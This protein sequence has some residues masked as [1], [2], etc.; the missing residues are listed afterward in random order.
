M[1]SSFFILADS[2]DILIEKH[3]RGLMNRSICEYF[4][5]QVSQSKQNGSSIPPIISTPK[6]YL[7]NIQKQHIYLLGVCQSEVS[8]LLVVDFLQ[9]I[10]ETFEEYFGRTITSVT[11]KENFVHVYQLLD[12]MTDNGFP[13]TTELNF[14]K[15]MIKPPGVLSNVIS[16]VT[17]TSNITDILPNGSLGAIQWRKTGIKYTQNKIFFDIIE[18]IDCILDSNGYIVSSEI[19][20]EILCHCN[21][22]GMPDLTMTFNN[23]R[24]LD[25]VSFHPC[26][27]YSRWEND[28]VLSFIPPDGNFK[29][30]TYRVKG[31]NQFPIYVKPQISYSEGSSSMGRVNVTIGAKGYNVQNKLS[32]EDVVATI[33]FSK[34]T[35]STNLTANIG[36]FGMDEQTKIL[37]WNIGKIPKEKTPFLNGSVSLIA[38]S[39]TPESTPSIMLQFKI[40]QYAISGL[41][42][43][44]LACSERYKPFKGV[45]CT[46]KAGKFQVRS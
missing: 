16:S 30:L 46:T 38:G 28:R 11:I 27:R 26:V 34:T 40:P 37:K 32:I 29:L 10:Y 15:E 17:G 14:L 36:S 21:L 42:I 9:R 19:N 2:G 43:D 5:D 31:I 35:S 33:P 20:G 8:P 1:L 7:I 22:S 44:S 3:W 18:E 6:Y 4:W 41:T 23:P 12:E 13:F 25:D 45:K 24:M 39:M